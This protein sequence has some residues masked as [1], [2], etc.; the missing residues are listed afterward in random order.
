MV[1]WGG[2]VG[3]GMGANVKWQHEGVM[4]VVVQFWVFAEVAL[5][6]YSWDNVT[7]NHAH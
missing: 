1:G 2:M 7:Q 6:I 3:L 4:V 5:Q